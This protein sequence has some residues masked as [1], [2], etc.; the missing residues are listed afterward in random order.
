MTDGDQAILNMLIQLNNS[1]LALKLLIAKMNENGIRVR[2]Q[3][4]RAP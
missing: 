3:E 1:V 4:S 2:T